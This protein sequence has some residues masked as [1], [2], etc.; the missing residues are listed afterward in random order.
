MNTSASKL[1]LGHFSMAV[2]L[3]LTFWNDLPSKA[4]DPTIVTGEVDV[5]ISVVDRQSI[6]E[7]D[8]LWDEEC[9]LSYEFFGL[10]TKSEGS[11]RVVFYYGKPN[12]APESGRPQVA[13]MAVIPFRDGKIHGKVRRW[14]EDGTLLVEVPYRN[15]LIDGECRFYGRNGKLLGTSTLKEGSGTYRIWDRSNESPVLLRE[16]KYA[17]GLSESASVGVAP[18]PDA[19]R[20]DAVKLQGVWIEEYTEHGGEKV[21]ENRRFI[22]VSDR[23]FRLDV[24]TVIEEG[25]FTVDSSGPIKK[26]DYRC[27]KGY[28]DN[29][30]TDKMLT[31]LAIYEFDGDTL[32]EF[33]PWGTDL[34]SNRPTAFSTRTDL[35]N[36]R[37][38]MKRVTW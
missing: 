36:Y 7:Y 35:T 23:F 28:L 8:I 14:A 27:L 20:V 3:L 12:H 4:A 32:R 21:A 16:I 26:I 22:F 18:D 1:S 10:K 13:A 37:R 25:F 34:W 5:T 6:L 15:G 9:L 31:R 19:G 30:G 33:G 11:E 17:A 2:A 38:V 24:D 29:R